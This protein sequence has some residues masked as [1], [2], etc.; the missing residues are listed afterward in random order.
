MTDHNFRINILIQSYVNPRLLSLYHFYIKFFHFLQS[1]NRLVQ[2]IGHSIRNKTPRRKRNGYK[3]ITYDD[4][5]I[6]DEFSKS[7]RNFSVYEPL[8]KKSNRK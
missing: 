6:H 4:F 1:P 3:G 5:T 7:S 2:V 8:N